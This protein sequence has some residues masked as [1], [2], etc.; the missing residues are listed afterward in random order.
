MLQRSRASRAASGA[1][2]LA[3]KPAR[4]VCGHV[5]ASRPRRRTFPAAGPFF[6][7]FERC[8]S[9]S[10]TAAAAP[11]SLQASLTSLLT[12]FSD[13]SSN[14]ITAD[15][16]WQGRVARALQELQGGP[17]REEQILVLRP[18]SDDDGD[19]DLL[20]ALTQDALQDPQARAAT[21]LGELRR[22]EGYT[23]EGESSSTSLVYAKE[24]AVDAEE[25]T[26]RGPWPL[27]KEI[28]ASIVE[29]QTN[30]LDSPSIHSH[31]YL[32][33]QVLLCLPF[34]ALFSPLKQ[35]WLADVAS[36]LRTFENHP[37]LRLV[38]THSG[39]ASADAGSIAQERIRTWLRTPDI[40][41]QFVDL[42]K[43]ARGQ[44][45]LRGAMGLPTTEMQATAAGPQ[46][47]SSL[48]TRFQSLSQQSGLP[49]L[50]SS[51]VET[52]QQAS[53]S[54]AVGS[55]TETDSAST[56]SST[57]SQSHLDL[58]TS[59]AQQHLQSRLSL[60]LSE[61][62]ALHSLATHLSSS[63]HSLADR[64]T[65]EIISSIR[66]DLL[67]PPSSNLTATA[68]ANEPPLL[69]AWWKLPLL[70]DA[71]VRERVQGAFE[72]DW[73]GGGRV[74]ETLIW[75]AGRLA[76]LAEEEKR[77]IKT[78]VEGLARD[79]AGTR[80][81]V[82][83]HL[84]V[85]RSSSSSSLSPPKLSVLQL[86]ASQ[87]LQLRSALTASSSIG[88]G[89]IG[90]ALSSRRNLLAE[91]VQRARDHVLGR[92]PRGSRLAK[93]ARTSV[94][95]A[96][97]ATLPPPS[98][99]DTIQTSV[100]RASYRFWTILTFSTS[101]S[102]YGRLV[103]TLSP[104]S[105]PSWLLPHFSSGTALGVFLLGNAFAL[106]RLQRDHSRLA[107]KVV[108]RDLVERVPRNVLAELE[109]VVKGTG[110]GIWAARREVGE[111]LGRWSAQERER[112]RRLRVGMS[113][114]DLK[115]TPQD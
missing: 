50:M 95:P 99:L 7:S 42:V 104:S 62:S 48:W 86:P 32:S 66:E 43:A 60:A 11:A 51:L 93:M 2:L 79:T 53:S 84:L 29:V 114:E 105:P 61:N 33:S 6:T 55:P 113:E 75:W 98:L 34:S 39:Q 27:L 82:E 35:A 37:G 8:L 21:L 56:T 64:L 40:P 3:A 112:L 115:R 13:S 49:N 100:Q 90:L 44:E 107:R 80:S 111:G 73:L 46:D 41:I 69:P 54:S 10:S 4:L 96:E 9:S 58:L 110:E 92:A 18:R 52:R 77:E 12:S 68:P 101:L 5:R 85:E 102:I 81:S 108:Q 23:K 25:R 36:L 65:S 38:V 103:A 76:V 47:R 15:A 106:L 72:R 19:G 91:P 22:A 24:I 14:S 63:S 74:E 88:T 16:A 57:S 109:A 83:D 59:H 78:L 70:G 17:V 97:P 71:A 87:L 26:L 94:D 67:R 31:L 45:A 89:D 30:N 28:A 20:G 1:P